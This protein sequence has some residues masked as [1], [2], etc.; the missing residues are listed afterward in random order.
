MEIVKLGDKAL[1]GLIREGKI[2]VLPTDTIYGIH[3][4]IFYPESIERIYQVR[5]RDIH[6]PL[7]ILISAMEDLNLLKIKINTQAKNFLRS[8]WPGKISVILACDYSWFSYL[9]RG[10]NTLAIRMPDSPELL[11]LLSQTGPLASTSVNPQNQASAE[12]IEQAEKYFGDKLDFYVDAGKL[13]GEP[14]TLVKL[15]GNKIKVIRE[16]AVKLGKIV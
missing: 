2:G 13:A 12:T 4:S 3:A 6:K 16:G 8:V 11:E 7:I 15:K 5:G 10:K 9:H 14:S 1:V